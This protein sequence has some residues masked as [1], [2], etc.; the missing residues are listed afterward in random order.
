VS[1]PLDHARLYGILDLG[2]VAPANAAQVVAEMIRGG[3]DVVQLRAKEQSTVE[4]TQ[5]ARELHRITAAARVPLVIN[6]YPEI[7]RVVGAEGV[8]VGQDDLSIADARAMAGPNCFVGRSTHSLE[9]ATRAAE[10]GADYIGFGPLF[11]TPTEPDY[12]PIGLG[13]IARV[14]ELVQLPIFCIGGIKLENLPQVL[15]AG[16]RRA[17]AA[18]ICGRFSSLMPPMQKIGSGTSSWTR[19]MSPRP[20]GM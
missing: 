7:A 11:T 10:G 12:L 15:A 1:G 13:N 6:D 4:I 5:I 19:A 2:Y 17:P 14:H 20:I 9:Q 18:M 16:A 8:H 3:V